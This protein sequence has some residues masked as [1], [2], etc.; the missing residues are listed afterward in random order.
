MNIE[1]TRFVTQSDRKLEDEPADNGS[2]LVLVEEDTG[3]WLMLGGGTQ[4]FFLGGIECDAF[5]YRCFR[6][7]SDQDVQ[8]HRMGSGWGFQGEQL[9]HGDVL[10]AEETSRLLVQL[11]TTCSWLKEHRLKSAEL[12]EDCRLLRSL[13]R[14]DCWSSDG[15][16]VKYLVECIAARDVT[17]LH[18]VRCLCCDVICN[19]G[20]AGARAFAVFALG[21]LAR[22][23]T[24]A[25]DMLAALLA[26][27]I[28]HLEIIPALFGDNNYSTAR[29]VAL[30]L[31]VLSPSAASRLCDMGF[32][33][34]L[35]YNAGGSL[36]GDWSRADEGTRLI[37][38]SETDGGIAIDD[39]K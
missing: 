38:R 36:W 8:V 12:E 19:E 18:E 30:M 39:S 33:Q 24:K 25:V 21:E 10:G 9:Q 11:V 34:W 1:K 6:G 29:A 2:M 4:W 22:H 31:A 17:S 28:L 23:D 7:W 27:G 16:S 37:R 26:D 35:K 5:P 20:H 13:I 15:A 14:V 32:R 3:K